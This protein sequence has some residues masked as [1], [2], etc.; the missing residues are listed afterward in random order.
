MKI[1]KVLFLSLMLI[2]TLSM[3]GCPEVT[4]RPPK[5]VQIVDGE[6]VDINQ[7]T[8][9]HIKGTEFHP[10]DMIDNLINQQNILAIDY[11]QEKIA[12]GREREYYD[13]SDRIFA[14]TFYTF[15]E[16]YYFDE[17]GNILNTSEDILFTLQPDDTYLDEFD[18]SYSLDDDGNLVDDYGIYIDNYLLF[19]NYDDALDYEES[20]YIL[21]QSIIYLVNV[22]LPVG[23]K[24]NFTLTVT[25]DDGAKAEVSG[26]INIIAE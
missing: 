7:V 23:N 4:N 2:L 24:Y 19:D 10:E 8:Y 20:N 14:I 26:V 15:T 3:M 12:I 17:D 16:A 6:V 1:K 25:D 9:N 22:L 11:D 18:Y 5:F 13:I 21:D